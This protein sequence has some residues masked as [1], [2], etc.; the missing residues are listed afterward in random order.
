MA[1]MN[2][3]RL[4]ECILALA[5]M[6]VLAGA[7]ALWRQQFDPDLPQAAPARRIDSDRG[8]ADAA[9]ADAAMPPQ[10]AV[11]AAPTGSPGNWLSDADYP[12]EAIRRG[13]SG[14]TGF[15]LKIDA[16]GAVESCVITASSGHEI[17]DDATCAALTRSARFTPGRNAS[18]TAAPDRYNGRISWR[19]PD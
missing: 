17:L 14:T 7:V 11:R 8:P 2:G 12:A 19:L 1:P 5:A 13:W 6:A 3:Q 16:S 4:R 10:A 15:R 18:G 9:P